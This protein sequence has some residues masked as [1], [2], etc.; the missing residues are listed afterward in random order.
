MALENL[1]FM[2]KIL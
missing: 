1:E 2:N